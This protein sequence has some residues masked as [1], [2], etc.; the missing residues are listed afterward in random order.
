MKPSWCRLTTALLIIGLT[1]SRNGSADDS[2]YDPSHACDRA[3]VRAEAE[4]HLPKGLLAAIGVV[5]S[6]RTGLGS[7]LP[8]PWPWAINANGRGYY[9]PSKEA[10]VAAIR[11]FRA[12]GV[13]VIDVGCFQV[14]LFYHP[15]AFD[16]L[17]AAFD[18]EA[19]AG[20]AARILTRSRLDGGS[21]DAAIALYHSA[22]PIRGQRYLR[23]VQSVWS[24][25]LARS[26]GSLH[27]SYV[28]LLSPAAARVRVLVPEHPAQPIAGMPRILG[29]QAS[30]NVLQWVAG[31]R[32]DLPIVLMPSRQFR[33]AGKQG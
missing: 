14:N 20:A 6:G 8:V 22:S 25:A 33:T 9:L 17:E 10:A 5:E 2:T 4:W 32:E 12:A 23:Q 11:A 26:E 24:F 31:A 27:A 13:S 29:P 1:L 19:N 16:N 15:T 30:A 3:A 7:T 28:A 18:A 21:W